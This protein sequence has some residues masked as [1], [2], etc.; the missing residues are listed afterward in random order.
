MTF[1]MFLSARVI[2]QLNV[3]TPLFRFF[4]AF[5]KEN[6]EMF[7]AMKVLQVPRHR[8]NIIVIW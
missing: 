7:E 2:Y 4:L 6:A 5:E 8:C 3:A 1:T